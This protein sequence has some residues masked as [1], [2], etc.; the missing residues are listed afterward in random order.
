MRRIVRVDEEKCNGCGVCSVICPLKIVS[1]KSGKA[2]IDEKLCDG[3]GGCVRKC[4]QEA[5]RLVEVD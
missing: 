5:M 2:V 4:P 1:L 3:L